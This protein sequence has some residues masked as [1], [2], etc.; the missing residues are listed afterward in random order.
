MTGGELTHCLATPGLVSLSVSAG[1]SLGVAATL[2]VHDYGSM[3]ATKQVDDLQA[4][5]HI[6]N[7]PFRTLTM[8]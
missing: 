4:A 2:Y 8:S 7:T 3:T 1:V 6:G 5:G